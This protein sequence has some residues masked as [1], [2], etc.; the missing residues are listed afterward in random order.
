MRNVLK[1][2]IPTILV[3][4]LT[5]GCG[6]T[7]VLECTMND[8]STEGLEMAHTVKATFKNDAVT[9]MDIDMVLTVDDE[10]KDYTNELAESLKSEF[11]NLDGK[12]GVSI[13][14]DTKDKVV[15]FNLTADLSK[16]DD[17]AKEELDMVGTSETYAAAKK[18]LEGEGYK[19]K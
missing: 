17:S 3:V 2:G 18:D 16:M 12:K 8:D 14:T 10:L 4:L 13:T 11:S 1:V 9:K 5:S 7:K 19:C 15:T 6:K